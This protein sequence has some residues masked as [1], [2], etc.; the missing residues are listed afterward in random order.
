MA[1]MNYIASAE[2]ANARVAH[3]AGGYLAPHRTADISLYQSEMERTFGEILAA[4]NPVGFDAS[5]LMPGA[6]G[7]SSGEASFWT[8]AVDI[9]TGDATVEEAFTRVEDN[10]PSPEEEQEEE[11]EE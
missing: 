11:E 5:D 10:W 8:A 4:G 7:S 1:T 3:E 6:V 2:F 9:T